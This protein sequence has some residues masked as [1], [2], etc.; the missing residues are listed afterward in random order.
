MTNIHTIH[1]ILQHFCVWATVC[2]Y[3]SQALLFSMQLCLKISCSFFP[4]I[5]CVPWN[6]VCSSFFCSTDLLLYGCF[7]SFCHAIKSDDIHY[8]LHTRELYLWQNVYWVWP[9]NNVVDFSF[10]IYLFDIFCYKYQYEWACLNIA[11]QY[12]AV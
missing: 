12:I 3:G 9:I 11:I 5:S 4:D 6:F 8:I 1:W 10:M 7:S 2:L